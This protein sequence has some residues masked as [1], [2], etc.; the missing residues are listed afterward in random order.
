MKS[1]R[2]GMGVGKL[3]SEK[4]KYCGGAGIVMINT[5]HDSPKK[6]TLHG[7]KSDSETSL[8]PTQST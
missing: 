4:T 2:A 3:K 8:R 6:I 1:N 7:Y 5:T